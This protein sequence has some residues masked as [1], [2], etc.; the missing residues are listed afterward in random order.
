[1]GNFNAN[2]QGKRTRELARKDKRAAKDLKRAQRKEEARAVRAAS[3]A[4]L[5]RTPAKAP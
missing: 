4:A 3:E 2:N 5:L 1:M